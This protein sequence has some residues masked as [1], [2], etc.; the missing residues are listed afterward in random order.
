MTTC[1]LSFN[2]THRL[3][4]S[5]AGFGRPQRLFGAVLGTAGVRRF[6][7]LRLRVGGCPSADP[8]LF[9]T[10]WACIVTAGVWSRR[11]YG[12]VI[13]GYGVVTAR[14][15]TR[16]NAV[17]KIYNVRYSITQALL[18]DLCLRAEPCVRRPAPAFRKWSPHDTVQVS[19]T[20]VGIRNVTAAEV[21][22]RASERARAARGRARLL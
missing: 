15:L 8:R 16:H 18:C 17:T 5:L 20:K 10:F 21:G 22:A 3:L 11:G 9:A 4:A 6:H 14:L 2:T 1:I 13:C 7:F 12:V 19:D